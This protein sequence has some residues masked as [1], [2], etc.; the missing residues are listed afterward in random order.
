[1][2][3][4]AGAPHGT[5]ANSSDL[6]G[7]SEVSLIEVFEEAG[8][9]EHVAGRRKETLVSPLPPHFPFAAYGLRI[10]QECVASSDDPARGMGSGQLVQELQGKGLDNFRGGVEQQIRKSDLEP[11]IPQ[12]NGAGEARIR[13][14]SDTASTESG[15]GQLKEPLLEQH[16][17][18]S[19]D[20]GMT[21]FHV[22]GSRGTQ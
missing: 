17:E 19:Q 13:V 3:Q 5:P 7:S 22:V 12:S 16:S 2:T 8:E 15:S 4:A 14:E 20:L 11:V 1:M 9:V 21:S 6:Q 18:L 10:V